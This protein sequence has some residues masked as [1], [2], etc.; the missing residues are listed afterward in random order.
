MMHHVDWALEYINDGLDWQMFDFE[1]DLL[2]RIGRDMSKRLI[3]DGKIML[4]A[5]YPA[6]AL[7]YFEYASALVYLSTYFYPQQQT[8]LFYHSVVD[9]PSQR[10]CRNTCFSE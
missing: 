3:E 1:T 9:A 6:F 5:D 2:V 7:K 10:L 4:N 8:S